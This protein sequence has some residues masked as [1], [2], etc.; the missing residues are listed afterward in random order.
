MYDEF[1]EGLSKERF[2]T[3][4]NWANQDKALA[5]ELYLFNAKICAEFYLPL[6]SFEICLRNRICSLLSTNYG[7]DWI[8]N[9]LLFPKS[10]INKINQAKEKL[11]RNQKL[12]SHPNL[13]ANL[14][15][16]FW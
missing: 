5:L 12:I 7:D 16:G 1:I 11:S 13:I 10:Q 6:Q 4:L 2:Q 8:V 15:F 9:K 14:S 3:Y